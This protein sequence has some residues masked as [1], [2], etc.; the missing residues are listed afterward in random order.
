M[1]QPVEIVIRA[2]D[3]F[4]PAFAGVDAALSALAERHASTQEALAV[5]LLAQD[6]R[7]AQ[8]REAQQ[9]AAQQRERQAL[10]AHHAAMLAA[11]QH[12]AQQLQSL[13]AT[14]AAARLET[15]ARLTQSLR[16]LAES[17]GGTLAR[18]AKALAIAEALVSAYLAGSKALASVP[19]PFN[20]AA[21]AAVTAQ[22][23]A[24]VERIRNV[25]VAHGGLERVPEDATFLL[26]R[27]ERVL[28]AAQNRDLTRFLDTAQQPA[29]GAGAVTIQNLTIRVLDNATSAEALLTM[30][31]AA[32]RQVVAERIVP[33]LDELARLGIRPR[34]VRENT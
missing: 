17:H 13:D 9:E 31:R 34:F 30:E 32:L 3:E 27:G 29:G 25:A 24:T 11:E 12:F 23:L 28:S 33:M 5:R 1:A 22:G 14:L 20:I 8:Q 10:A 26:Q 6:E 21:A 4:T 18:T 7:S 19:F 2:V 16:A 15:F